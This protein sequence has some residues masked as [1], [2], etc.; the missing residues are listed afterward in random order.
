MAYG[1]QHTASGIRQVAYGKRPTPS[2]IWQAS[3]GKRHTASGI[4]QAAYGKRHKASGIRQAAYSKRHTASELEQ[5]HLDWVFFSNGFP[6]KSNKQ[7]CH[8]ITI[9]SWIWRIEFSYFTSLTKLYFIRHVRHSNKT[10]LYY[11]KSKMPKQAKMP[12]KNKTKVFF[13]LLAV[14]MYNTNQSI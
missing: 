4:R 8:P 9:K 12:N 7:A 14:K 2:G 10:N 3:Y 11:Y 6:K 13:L 5:F 1:K